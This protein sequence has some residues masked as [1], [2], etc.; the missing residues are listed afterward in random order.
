MP[1]ANPLA[2]QVGDTTNLLL[3]KL[4]TAT[5]G[6]SGAIGAVTSVNGQIGAVALDAADVGAAPEFYPS[7]S[8]RRVY[9]DKSGI[10]ATADGT[11]SLPFLTVTGALTAI[12]LFAQQP[13]VTIPVEIVL[14]PG[15]YTEAS[16]YL[17]F[18]VDITGSGRT[19]TRLDK[20]LTVGNSNYGSNLIRD[21][22]LGNDT[23]I[24][25]IGNAGATHYALF[26]VNCNANCTINGNAAAGNCF[27]AIIGCQGQAAGDPPN[28]G[29]TTVYNG[30]FIITG[31]QEFNMRCGTQYGSTAL[32]TVRLLGCQ[33]N[34]LSIEGNANSGPVTTHIK[35]C[36]VASGSINKYGGASVL[37][38]IHDALF[39]PSILT[40]V[41]ADVVTLT[42]LAGLVSYPAAVPGNWA[43]AAPTTIQAAIDRLAA[44]NPGA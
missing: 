35:A 11:P 27:T 38:L 4:V 12:A 8:T 19:A 15:V 3:K 32:T 42:T 40:G 31:C 13:A 33:V 7:A 20:N 17:P 1:P 2:P 24:S 41:A 29:T 44:A 37:T 26:V 21:L 43:G 18:Y 10:D 6:I 28:R 25:N 36:N 5:Q 16:S 9:V 14:G 23:T 30:V 39:D 34:V 22:T